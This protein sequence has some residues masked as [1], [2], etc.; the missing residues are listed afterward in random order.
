MSPVH[1]KYSTIHDEVSVTL[2]SAASPRTPWVRRGAALLGAL[3]GVAALCALLRSPGAR[4]PPPPVEGA[5]PRSDDL[6]GD[7]CEAWAGRADEILELPGEGLAAALATPFRQFSGYLAVG[8][9]RLFYYFAEADRADDGAAARGA[10]PLMLWL[11]GGPGCSSL[12]GL[13]TENGPFVVGPRGAAGPLAKN[14]YAWNKAAHVLWLEQPAGVGF[15][16]PARP[17][18]DRSAAADV[19][20]ALRC[21]ARKHPARAAETDRLFLSG[22]SYAGHYVPRTAEAIFA[23]GAA[24]ARRQAEPPG[25]YDDEDDNG[26]ADDDD[27][28]AARRLAEMLRRGGLLVGNG[29]ADHRLDFDQVVP[30]AYSHAL[31]PRRQYDAV[32]SACGAGGSG[33]CMWP[34]PGAPCD[35]ACGA[36]TE[37]ALSHVFAGGA[38]SGGF[39]E[40]DVY[41]VLADVCYPK[42]HASSSPRGDAAA[43]GDDA[44]S[45]LDLLHR[46]MVSDGARPRVD[47]WPPSPPR[48][49]DGGG[50]SGGA[51]EA[52]PERVYP[53]C[54]E[55]YA[56]RWLNDEAVQRALHVK[57]TRLAP[58]RDDRAW[59]QCG[60]AETGLY[61]F[62]YDSML[63]LYARWTSAA[64][65]NASAAP[66]RLLIYSGDAD[67]LVNV[68]GTESWL[69]ELALPVASEWRAWRG[70]DGQTAGYTMDH[71]HEGARAIRFATIKGAGH[72][73]PKD[74]PR[75]SLDMVKAFLD[76]A[77]L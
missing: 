53:T 35:A 20:A 18:G 67:L 47:H 73:V 31:V 44:A 25:S 56:E 24:A 29:V 70:S 71:G 32:M 55:A 36:A 3:G 64:A 74:R 9:R 11:N 39:G 45:L 16:V 72:M 22:E 38:G 68:L 21:F 1:V 51:C 28:R 15:S 66:G 69:R 14:P 6:P 10:A 46:A 48:G 63:P 8:D 34:R 58:A 30:Y 62:S 75:H 13:L 2:P 57:S 60:F 5:P 17:A 4:A 33:R 27:D 59:A 41:D 49:G 61:N 37:A 12:G 77:P 76:E 65:A 54:I 7:V 52:G 42:P 23:A 50:A 43:R 26:D 40:I 19:A